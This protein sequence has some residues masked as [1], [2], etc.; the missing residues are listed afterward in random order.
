LHFGLFAF[1]DPAGAQYGGAGVMIA[2]PTCRLELRPAEQLMASGPDASRALMF[3]RRY[4]QSI[5]AHP[6]PSVE[7]V[8]TS[9][10]RPH[11]GLGSGTQLGLAV[12]RGLEAWLQRPTEEAPRLARRVGRGLRSAVGVHGFARGGLIVEAGKTSADEISPLLVHLELPASWRWLLAWPQQAQGLSGPD[13]VEAFRQ[14]PPVPTEV[15][16]ALRQCALERLVPAGRSADFEAFSA[17]LF[18]YGYLAGQCFKQRQGGIYYS[19]EATALTQAWR[20]LEIMG[21]GQSSWGPTLFAL[22]E[23][24][25]Q[26]NHAADQLQQEERF[27]QWEFSLTATSTHGA[28]VEI[29]PGSSDPGT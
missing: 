11:S 14:L 6:L 10:P 4:L 16:A 2:S 22:C 21:V 15:T 9:S 23:S 1:G 8:I 19:P 18:D 5:A 17:A 3:A 12:G 29:L 26:A 25:E 7:I 27:R 13:E 28:R 24:D 20:G